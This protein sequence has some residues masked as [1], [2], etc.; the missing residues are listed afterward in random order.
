MNSLLWGGSFN[1]LVP[2]YKRLPTHLKKQILFAP[3]GIEMSKGYI[4]GFDPDFI[5]CDNQNLEFVLNED[6]TR[7]LTSDKIIQNISEHW[8]PNY[9]VG[10]FELLQHIY[11]K[12]LKFIRQNP[13]K[14]IFPEFENNY[15]LF[16][17]SVFGQLSNQH[18]MLV[19]ENYDQL[20]GIERPKITLEDYHQYL[21]SDILFP[22]RISSFGLNPLKIR[23]RFVQSNIYIHILDATNT[24]DIIDYW[25]LRASGWSVFPLPKQILHKTSTIQL[26]KR[27]VEDNYRPYHQNPSIYHVSGLL[28]GR[29][30]PYKVVEDFAKQI[31][32]DKPPQSEESKFFL[33]PHYPRFWDNWARDKDGVGACEFN[34]QH[35][36]HEFSSIP[37][38]INIPP[39]EPEFSS[40]AFRMRGRLKFANEIE[41]RAYGNDGEPYAEIIPENVPHLVY[42]F[43]GSL[44]SDWRIS[45]SGLVAFPPYYTRKISFS[46]PRAELIMQAWFENSNWTTRLSPSGLIAKQMLN[47]VGGGYG[48]MLIAKDPLIKLF[49]KITRG[50]TIDHKTL[51]AEIQKISNS[52]KWPRDPHRLL[53]S[54]VEKNILRIGVEIKCPIC[55]QKSWYSISSLDYTFTC[56]VC[57]NCSSIPSHSPQEIK[58]SYRS[59]GAFNLPHRAYGVYSVLLTYLFFLKTMDGATTPIFSFNLENANRKIESDLCL[60][61][62]EAGFSGTKKHLIFAE[63]KT[64]NRFKKDDMQRMKVI[65]KEFPGSV[66]VFATLNQS[67]TKKE[68]RLLTP[69]VLNGRKLWKDNK[70]VCPVLVLTATE[71]FAPSRFGTP[72]PKG[73]ANSKLKD[74]PFMQHKLLHLCDFTQQ[75]Y[76]DLP[77]WYDWFQQQAK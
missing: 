49:D 69:F 46:P 34:L 27:L 19:R 53:E 4:E 72:Y 74:L 63:C 2:V 41:F 75:L 70:T 56:P 1:P 65:S 20:L 26:V 3:T 14:I 10:V 13:L 24:L 32:V 31:K 15:E 7:K 6:D 23:N 11:D 62:R 12:E 48:I 25:N 61:F 45:K 67:L 21:L 58:W 60:Y 8:A 43:G 17:L 40:V 57:L 54:L 66:I 73:V 16:L 68:K 22:R 5:I 30:I 35:Q 52:E 64:Y 18:D 71:L 39:L 28:K 37:D 51:W 50:K 9:G 47:Q 33:Q 29:S 38:Q 36:T 44:S 55:Q 42:A 59:Y 76:L 77:S